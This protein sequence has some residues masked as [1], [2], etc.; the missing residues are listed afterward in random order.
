MESNHQDYLVR[1][2]LE[3]N[4]WRHHQNHPTLLHNMLVRNNHHLY[5][6]LMTKQQEMVTLKKFQNLNHSTIVRQ[7]KVRLLLHHHQH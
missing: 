2:L 4:Q 6:H 1:R 5:R 3:Y 7:V